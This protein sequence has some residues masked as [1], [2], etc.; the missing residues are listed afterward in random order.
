MCSTRWP[1]LTVFGRWLTVAV[2]NNFLRVI[3]AAVIT[4]L[5]VT[6][7]LQRSTYAAGPC[8][9]GTSPDRRQDAKVGGWDIQVDAQ[10]TCRGGVRAE[11]QATY[12]NAGDARRSPP[13]GQRSGG[14][15]VTSVP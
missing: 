7:G 8:G 5:S 14:S 13:E 3:I 9:D 15:S 1:N 10:R 2:Q 6:V 4:L 12:Q 11:L